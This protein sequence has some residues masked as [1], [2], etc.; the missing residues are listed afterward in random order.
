MVTGGATTRGQTDPF[1]AFKAVQKQGWAHF[2]PMEMITALPAA[3]L[4]NF[5]GVRSGQDVLDV[6]CGTGVVA[7]TAA[8]MGAKVAGLDLTPEL[9]ER[10]R[11]NS[12]VAGVEVD[13]HEGD[14]E[15]LPFK[16][17]AFEVVLSQFGHM[18]APRP[19]VAIAEMLRVLKPGGTMAFSTWPP[20]QMVGRM[21]VLTS[22]YM[23]PP[24]P[25]VAPP[26]QWGDKNTV[27]ERLGSAMT[28]IEFVSGTMFTPALS[29]QHFRSLIERTVGP[30]IKLN[31]MLA[32]SDPAKLS[33][34]RRECE[35]L[36]AEYF[37]ENTVKQEYLM[38][39]AV[40]N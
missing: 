21:F 22:R 20:D 28:K 6:G 2:T 14:A 10:A 34:F 15:E 19:N 5:A 1:E 37:Q 7:V 9:V 39:R 33:A 16:D 18:F 35:A 4:V 38:T 31:E 24:P 11:S 8:R 23:P 36:A 40:K 17:G 25:G 32:T 30:L 12:K 29:P 27:R 13:W 26:V 3:C